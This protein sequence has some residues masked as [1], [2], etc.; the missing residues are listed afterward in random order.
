MVVRS[1]PAGCHA[2]GVYGRR[3]NQSAYQPVEK[4]HPVCVRPL[5]PKY[6]V[7]LPPRIQ[8]FAS[9]A[10]LVFGHNDSASPAERLFQRTVI[11]V[12]KI[13]GVFA[14]SKENRLG[15]GLGE[16]SPGYPFLYS[17]SGGWVVG[18][19]PPLA[20]DVPATCETP[21]ET[22]WLPSGQGAQADVLAACAVAGRL[23]LD[24]SFF[25]DVKSNIRKLIKANKHLISR[26]LQ[27]TGRERKKCAS[28]RHFWP[29]EEI[30][31]GSPRCHTRR[32][33]RI[34]IVP[35]VLS[36]ADFSVFFKLRLNP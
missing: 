30:T 23:N 35:F 36:V 31:A 22:R 1:K 9:V 18:Y 20:C 14:Q 5:C 32:F 11:T 10:R 4:V 15:R 8:G 34:H 27:V 33:A 7:A 26:M 16:V 6:G 2:G 12:L 28:G 17:I 19:P 13:H 24:S 21:S 25:G 29:G 3:N